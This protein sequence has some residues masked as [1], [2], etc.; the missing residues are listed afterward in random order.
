MRL[1]TGRLPVTPVEL[2]LARLAATWG[3]VLNPVN[4]ASGPD[5]FQVQVL[6]VTVAPAPVG[7]VGAELF[8]VQAARLR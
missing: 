7:K 4:T 3:G 5:S 6:S 2:E 8:D 1:P